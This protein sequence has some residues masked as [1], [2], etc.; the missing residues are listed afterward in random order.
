M[1]SL[2]SI[3][4]RVTAIRERIIEAARRAG[5]SPEEVRL[6]AVT[7]PIPAERVAEAVRAGVMDLAENYVQEARAKIPRVGALCKT[8]VLWHM[9]GHLQSNKARYSIEQFSLIQTVHNYQ[10]AQEL[11]ILASKRG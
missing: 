6:V 2:E 1:Q 7:K 8:P 4:E 10:L 3:A 5:R 9:I 11:G